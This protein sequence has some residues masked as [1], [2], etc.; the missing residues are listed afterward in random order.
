[1]S[2]RSAFASSSSFRVPSGA[3]S[4]APAG[5]RKV[6]GMLRVS[7]ET[8]LH[9][10]PRGSG[11]HPLLVPALHWQ[12][13]RCEKLLARH[14]LVFYDRHQRQV[15]RESLPAASALLGEL[16]ALCFHLGLARVS[17]LG[18][19]H[20][21]EI[22]AHYALEHSEQVSRLVLIRPFPEPSV[23][24]GEG[25]HALLMGTQGRG[26]PGTSSRSIP[27]L[28]IHGGNDPLP[29]SSSRIWAAALPNARLLTM[30]GAG[31]A[32]S[33]D[34]PRAFFASV[35][36]FLEGAVARRRGCAAVP[37]GPMPIFSKY[38]PARLSPWLETRSRCWPFH[39][40]Q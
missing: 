20:F 7:D 24:R 1:M 40:L 23:Q 33:D 31:S 37:Y 34:T 8:R 14:T 35:T 27:T 22:A 21:G 36:Q 3:S 18:W 15:A 29:V 28:I 17:L 11:L 16:E 6:E 26:L 25:E 39:S 13:A 32:P 10:Q 2:Q 19:S 38:G 5:A 30:Q 9:Y 4:A 12:L